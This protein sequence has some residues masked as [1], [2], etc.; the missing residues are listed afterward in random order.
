MA[1]VAAQGGAVASLALRPGAAPGAAPRHRARLRRAPGR[2]CAAACDPHRGRRPVRRERQT[3]GLQRHR[4]RRDGA[5][6]RARNN[7]APGEFR[8]AHRLA[9][10]RADGAAHRTRHRTCAALAAKCGAAAD[11][12]GPLQVDQ[13]HARPCGGRRVA[14]RSVAAPAQLRASLRRAPLGRAQP[15]RHAGGAPAR[16]HRAIGGRRVRRV[17]ARGQRRA[18]RAWH[19]SAHCGV[20]ACAHFGGWRGMFCQRRSGC[21]TVPAR[22]AQRR[23]L[24]AQRRCGPVGGEGTGQ[25][26]CTPIQP[27]T[28]RQGARTAGVGKCLAQGDRAQRA[29]IALPAQDRHR[30]G[31]HGGRRGADALAAR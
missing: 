1:S 5:P 24:A 11:Q 30:F 31:P 28:C 19:C 17:A 16:M 12:P 27:P 26:R 22:C 6:D 7:P 13:R 18:A 3:A 2:G 25:Q 21:G 8:R 14:P 15:A 23:G 10:S 9:E 20:A 4:A 29:G